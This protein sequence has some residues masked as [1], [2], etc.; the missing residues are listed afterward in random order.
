MAITLSSIT[1]STFAATKDEQGHTLVS[2]WKSYYSAV[3]KDKPKEQATILENIKK[4]AKEKRLAW[5][6]Y[7]ACNKYVDARVSTNWKLRDELMAQKSTELREY[8]EPIINFTVNGG[9]VASLLEYVQANKERMQNAYNPEFYP[10]DSSFTGPLYSDALTPLVKNDYDFAL[11]SIFIRGDRWNRVEDAGSQAIRARYGDEYPFVAFIDYTMSKNAYSDNQRRQDLNN[12]IA[13]YNGKAVTLFARQNLISMDFSNLQKDNKSTGKDYEKIKAACEKFVA[14]QKTFTGSEKVIADCCHSPQNLLATMSEKDINFNIEDGHLTIRVRNLPSVKFEVIQKTNGDKKQI[15]EKTV[16][17]KTIQNPTKSYYVIDT[18]TYDIPPINDGVYTVRCSNGKTKAESSY[19]KTTLSIACKRDANGVG[20]YVADYKTGKPVDKVDLTITSSDNVTV[21]STKGLVINGFTYLPKDLQERFEKDFWGDR[22]T[23]TATI[24]GIVRKSPAQRLYFS[25]SYTERFPSKV[26]MILT[27]RAA[28]NP[29][30]TVHYKVILYNGE[31][32][33]NVMKDVKLTAVLLDAEG[34]EIDKAELTTGEFG[35]AAGEFV[36]KRRPRNGMYTICI[37]TA[38]DEDY[39]IERKSVRVDDFVLPTFE[40][41]W[42]PNEKFYLPDDEI[43]IKGKVKSYSG[44]SLTSATSKYTVTKYGSTYQ[45]GDLKLASDGTFEIKFPA[46]SDSF[47]HYTITVTVTDATGE[48]QEFETS[49]ISLTDI[50][51]SLS[52]KNAATGRF[53][54]NNKKRGQFDSGNCRILSTD[55]AEVFFD[56]REWPAKT[57]LKHA[58]LKINYEVKKGETVIMTGTAASGQT[59]SIDFTGKASGLYTIIATATATDKK[60]KEHKRV[61]KLNLLKVLDNDKTLEDGVINFFKETSDEIGIQFGHTGAP[62]WAVAELY[63]TGDVLLEKKTL[64]LSGKDNLKKVAFD[65]KDSYPDVVSLRIFYFLDGHTNEYNKV[66]YRKVNR[67]DLPLSFSRFLDTTKPGATYTFNIKTAAGVECA[68]TIFDKSTET[69]A[70][71]VWHSVLARKY[72]QPSVN[73]ASSCGH[74]STQGFYYGL[75]EMAGGRMMKAAAPAR[76]AVRNKAA[77]VAD[78]MAPEPEPEVMMEMASEES[79]MGYALNDSME[80]DEEMPDGYIRENFANTIAWEP[81]LKSDKDGNI[82]FKFTNADK[83]STYYVQL[84]A[85]QTNMHN[86]TLRQEMVVTIPV[87]IAVVEP[88]VLYTGDKYLLRTTLANNSVGPVS[89]RLTVTVLDGGDLNSSPAISTRTKA[90]TVPAGGNADFEFPIDVPTIETLGLKLVFEALGDFGSDGVFVSVPVHKAVQEITEAHS[91][92]LLAGQDRD[93]LIASLRSQFV[94]VAG[95]DANLKETSIID[96]IRE[97]LPKLRTYDSE[98]AISLT[99]AL[100]ANSLISRIEGKSDWDSKEATEKLKAC[101]NLDGG[102]GWF[103]GFDSSPMVTAVVLERFAA[104]K[105]IQN[106]VDIPAAVN[107]LDNCYLEK[108]N[109]PYWC[110]NISQAQYLYL[111]SLYPAVKLDT[112]GMGLRALRQFKKDNKDYL[113][114]AKVRGLNGQILAKARRLKT[115]RNLV[116]DPAGSS[117]ASSLGI[118]SSRKLQKS[119]QA[120]IESL[121]EYAEPHKSGGTYYPNAVMP[122]RGLL[123]SELY[124]H[125]L[126]CDLLSDCGHEEVADGIRLWIMVQKE[127]QK[128][129]EDPA[130]IEAIA[131]VLNGSEAVLQTKVVILSATTTLPFADIKAS[132]NGF[133][134]ERHYY[135]DG[136]EIKDGEVLNVGDKI[137]AKFRIWNEEN[138]SFV[139][140][141]VPRNGALRPV[142]Q[143]SGRIGWRLGLIHVPGWIAFGPQGYRNVLADRTEFWYE[144]YPEE[145]TTLEEEYFVTQAG[146]FQSPVPVIESLYSPHYRANGTSA[147]MKTK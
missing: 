71:N 90:V 139:R 113:V 88:R 48:T 72:P 21:A 145:N 55:K 102:F 99:E 54:T 128:W 93:A 142:E 86:A 12:Y 20:V 111:R 36:L 33:L 83:L 18:L 39:P 16:H 91:S 87:K 3:D 95:K 126:L 23:A 96:M 114:P 7:D 47:S 94:N 52:L 14:D 85:H 117:L 130:Y 110:G 82:S 79:E 115:L 127:T 81:F 53:Y 116:T 50:P 138:R 97:A 5:D 41:T 29:D 35:S 51:L 1:M 4:E 56:V 84:F 143:L 131:S 58:S 9:N 17:E 89:G 10:F 40:L 107:Y 30:E 98:N 75:D 68:A 6:F 24:D 69:M 121:L 25:R 134:L 42:E 109:R 15:I 11:W 80:A 64:V 22:I 78:G 63:G 140:L 70:P 60:G 133:T 44:H 27:D 31:Y 37:F 26:A 104:M 108:R 136:I 144:S 49:A 147:V 67:L 45:K 119:L 132:G 129:E 32:D 28:F 141:T 92:I 65:Y 125:S 2:L 66:V 57:S 61:E 122:W 146:T 73:Y 124:A 118:S 8:D 100:Y 59:C 38:D 74:N 13:K 112:G 76:S 34:D 137:V 19:D 105:S 62:V 135:R 103:E 120:D 46:S 106:T 101:Q 43:T 123:E 77:A